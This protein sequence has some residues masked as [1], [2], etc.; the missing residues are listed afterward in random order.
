MSRQWAAAAT[1]TNSLETKLLDLPRE[2]VC[3]RFNLKTVFSAQEDLLLWALK[4]GRS[5]VV[6]QTYN[7]SI[8]EAEAGGLQ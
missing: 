5:G 6:V 7:P 3:L 8:Q 1:T 4:T 2:R